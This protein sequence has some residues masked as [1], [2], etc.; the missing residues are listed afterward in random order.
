MKL[1]MCDVGRQVGVAVGKISVEQQW[2]RWWWRQRDAVLVGQSQRLL[3]VRPAAFAWLALA[4][5]VFR[6]LLF[7]FLLSFFYSFAFSALTL[8]V[9]RQEEHPRPVILCDEMVAWTRGYL[10]GGRC[11]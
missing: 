11:K 8:S 7:V 5:H 4:V 9:R 10:S 6:R 3:Q 2:R 1:V